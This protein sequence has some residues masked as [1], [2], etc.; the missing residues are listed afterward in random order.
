MQE[1]IEQAHPEWLT[2]AR[3]AFDSEGDAAILV[4][5]DAEAAAQ[6]APCA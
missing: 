5:P 3:V 6:A 4:V 1:T 2:E